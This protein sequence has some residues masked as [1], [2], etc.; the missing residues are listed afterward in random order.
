MT[1]SLL[2][3][4]D[5][6]LDRDVVG[7]VERLAP[8]APVPVLDERAVHDRPG[9]A[10]LAAWLAAR[11]GH[12][13]TLLTALGDDDAGRDL[14]SL[15]A[16]SGV[17]VA[18]L[19]T[20][21][22]TPEKIRLCAGA[23][24]L[25]RLDR[26]GQAGGVIGEL[27]DAARRALFAAD[28]VLVSDYGRGLSASPSLREA[29][30]HLA[31]DVP[32]VWDPHSRGSPP[33]RGV[34]L[35]TPN[36]AEAERIGGIGADS[37]ADV[38]S[39]ARAVRERWGIDA[40]VVTLGSEGALLL[41]GGGRPLVVPTGA[42]D[43]DPCGAGDRFASRVAGALMG[44]RTLR[45]AVLDGIACASAFVAA[46]GAMALRASE[47]ASGFDGGGARGSAAFH[48]GDEEPRDGRWLEDARTGARDIDAVALAERVRAA[49][50]TVVATGGCFDLL[51][52]GHVAMLRAARALGD[53]LIVCLNSDASV[54]RLKGDSRP[55]NSAADRKT[56]LLGLE[57]VD[58]V[59][60]FDDDTP[61]HAL[62]R[63]RPHVWAK[64]ADYAGAE[65]PE[66]T[67]L[68]AWGG[69]AVLLPYLENRSTTRLV[70]EV[71]RRASN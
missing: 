23:R 36:R 15:L 39:A 5:A 53:C 8:D 19:G 71:L 49:G 26:G 43:G 44:G 41:E 6:L 14:A 42:T 61:V 1:G 45:D 52:A 48:G 70:Q 40:V 24:P 54:R 38:A 55:L 10:A 68:V 18:D 65:L 64:A 13:V 59:C 27:S 11:D 25:L 69:Q 4:G 46:G 60:V 32:I 16:R 63:L 31:D 2:V 20:T 21:S 66:A 22:G 28:A 17:Q 51:H 9:G 12:D 56:V 57:P 34:R 47:G 29:L 62:G 7:G 37:L 50:G 58:A 30:E 67:A 3:V 35:V 33:V